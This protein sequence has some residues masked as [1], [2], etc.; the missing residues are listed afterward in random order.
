MKT[1]EYRTL[2]RTE[3]QRGQWDSEPDKKQ[4]LDEAT[5]LP[6]LIV[7]QREA[8]HLCGYV[9]VPKSHPLH[10]KPERQ[11]IA[12]TDAMRDVEY[13]QQTTSIFALLGQAVRGDDQTISL[14]CLC[15]CH[16]GLT[17]AASCQPSEDESIGICHV[18]ETPEEDGVWWFGFDCAHCDDLSYFTK[19]ELSRISREGIYR[20]FEYVAADCA[21]LARQ[22]KELETC[23]LV[24]EQE[25]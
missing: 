14:D 2:D 9:G 16:G 5:G 18:A 22:L 10:G 3:W 8:G 6:C 12:V 19:P 24:Q 1:I 13:D 23:E 15:Q 11:L 25:A 17:F 4:W 21:S 20:D 7:R